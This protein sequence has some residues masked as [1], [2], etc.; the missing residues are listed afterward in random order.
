PSSALQTH[1]YN[2]VYDSLNRL[3]S[4]DT[5]DSVGSGS[6]KYHNTFTY[7]NL[8]NRLSHTKKWTIQSGGHHENGTFTYNTA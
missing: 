8:G 5:D 1:K 4:I 7:D 2:L 3:S 6:Y